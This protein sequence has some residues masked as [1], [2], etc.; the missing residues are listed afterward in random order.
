MMRLYIVRHGEAQRS[1]A[2]DADRALTAH[3]GEVVR[4]FWTRLAA[5]RPEPARIVS[6]SLRRARETARII[7]DI[8]GGRPPLLE[9]ELLVPE[10]PPAET[11]RW[12]ELQPDLD[13]WVLVSH[14]PLVALL[15][16]LLVD[17]PGG[18]YPFPLSGVACLDLA[19]AC[20]A[21]ARLLWLKGP[22]AA[23]GPA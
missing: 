8:H 5:D 19:V 15:T 16:G 18:R 11:A 23:D 3:G 1:A 14:M 22:D 13:T 9:Q 12:L 4:R 7:Q 21:G 20:P 17:G 10:A 2:T 6:S